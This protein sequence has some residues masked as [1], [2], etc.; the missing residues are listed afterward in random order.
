MLACIARLL[1]PSE[2]SRA[3]EVEVGNFE[4]S[5]RKTRCHVDGQGFH[6]I[7]DNVGFKNKTLLLKGTKL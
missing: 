2:V 3:S 1:L 6:M 7:R 5:F 4:A